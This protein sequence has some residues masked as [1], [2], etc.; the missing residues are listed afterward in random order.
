MGPDGTRLMPRYVI[1]E[2]NN[3][4]LNATGSGKGVVFG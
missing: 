3:R 2:S 4:R 1:P